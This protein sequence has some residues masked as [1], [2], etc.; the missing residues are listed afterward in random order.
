[1]T[2][3]FNRLLEFAAPGFER[4]SADLLWSRVRWASRHWLHRIGWPGVLA[5]GILAMC[6]AFYWSTIRPEQARLNVA[7][8]SIA[9]LHQQ[10]AL[11]GKTP[12]GGRLSSED[13][14]AEFY[15]K[16]PYEVRSPQYLEKLVALAANCGLTLNDGEYKATREKV[17]RLVRYQIALPVKGEYPQIR[18]FLTELP[19]ALQ[20]VA[21]ENVQFERK[22]V[23]DRNV[24]AKIKLVLYLE[25][26]S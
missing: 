24:D 14:L 8:H 19:G 26:A 1:M 10:L 23:S 9:T 3:L 18:K 11:A 13:Q 21:L 16:F 2:R 5:V 17:G 7:R 25:Q 4:F 22:K 15:S 20:V 12:S 6:L